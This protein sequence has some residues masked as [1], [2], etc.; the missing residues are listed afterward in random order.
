MKI[1]GV[2][3]SEIIK[4]YSQ[5]KKGV[6]KKEEVSKSDSI[7]ISSLGKSLSAYSLDGNFVNRDEKIEKLR[8]EVSSGT[9]KRDSKLVAAKIIEEMKRK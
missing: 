3:P 2:N 9:Y 8:N 5:N 6:E 7:Q 4:L 1:N